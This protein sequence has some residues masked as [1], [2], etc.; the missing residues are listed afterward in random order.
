MGTSKG[1]FEP[2]DYE[3]MVSKNMVKVW[4]FM[5]HC[6]VKKQ[7]VTPLYAVFLIFQSGIISPV[8]SS[9]A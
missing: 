9:S 6:R 4:M 2:Q 8:S 1:P 5:I 3:F 7:V